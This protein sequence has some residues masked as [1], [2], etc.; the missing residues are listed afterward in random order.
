MWRR[1]KVFNC[2]YSKDRSPVSKQELE[3]LIY[4]HEFVLIG[5][6]E[7]WL[8]DLHDWNVEITGCNLFRNDEAGRKSGKW[9]FMSEKALPLSKCWQ[10]RS[11][12]Y[13]RFTGE[14]LTGKAQSTSWDLLQV[15]VSQQEAR[16]SAE[17]LSIMQQE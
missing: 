1:K 13:W 11:D 15:T 3:W 2:L 16:C 14:Y 4:E 9:H 6:T 10:C 7:S 5:I 12:Q 17:Y 8:G